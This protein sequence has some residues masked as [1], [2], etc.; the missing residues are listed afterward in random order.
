MTSRSR[1]DKQTRKL[2]WDKNHTRE[3]FR[4]YRLEGDEAA[5]R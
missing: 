5:R 4:R 2:S 1:A 3:L